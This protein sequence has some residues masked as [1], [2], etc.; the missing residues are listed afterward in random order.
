MVH[1]IERAPPSDLARLPAISMATRL[2]H[3]LHIFQVVLVSVPAF[4]RFPVARMHVPLVLSYYVSDL[5]I[6]ALASLFTVFFFA[7]CRKLVTT[8][9]S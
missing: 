6:V 3:V 8:T 1:G 5:Y 4:P 7:F 2:A 9:L